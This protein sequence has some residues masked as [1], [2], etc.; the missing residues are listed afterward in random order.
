M[1]A[2]LAIPF[3]VFLIVLALYLSAGSFM[4]YWRTKKF[5]KEDPRPIFAITKFF[6]GIL[7]IIEFVH[8]FEH[9]SMD[10]GIGFLWMYFLLYMCA[11][12]IVGW[13]R[14]EPD[15]VFAGIKRTLHIENKK[16]NGK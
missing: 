5:I 15:G 2:T 3:R 13:M 7:A 16:R 1:T 12:T 10:I 8:G 6:G 4:Y 9:P 14:V 11:S